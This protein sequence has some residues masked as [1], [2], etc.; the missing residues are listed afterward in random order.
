MD[1]FQEELFLGEFS[2]RDYF[3]EIISRSA[4]LERIISKRDYFWEKGARHAAA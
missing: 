1:Y 3:Q 2:R 4:F